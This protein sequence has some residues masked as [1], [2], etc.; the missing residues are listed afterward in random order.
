MTSRVSRSFRPSVAATLALGL[1]ALLFAS[2]GTWQ[3]RRAAEKAALETEHENAPTM[4]LEAA[5]ANDQRFARVEVSGRYDPQRHVLLDNQLWQ[6]RGGVH[7]FT[8]FSTNRGITIL[9]NR[10]WLPLP[11]DRKSLPEIPTPDYQVT[12]SGT[13]NLLPVPGRMV[14]EADTLVKDDW[15]QL[16][17]YMQHADVA[18]ALALEL[19]THIIQLSRDAEYGFEDRDWKPVFLS[20]ERHRAYAFQWYALMAAA[21]VLWLLTSFRKTEGHRP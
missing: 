1:L 17:T 19:E 20:P 8:P 12:L 7:V 15:P 2:L 13:L 14:G 6:G 9:V 18:R 3:T 21:I 10:G 5:L 4:A 16:V 11:A